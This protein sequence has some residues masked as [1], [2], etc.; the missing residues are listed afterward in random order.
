MASNLDDLLKSI[1]DE[2]KK[3]SAIVTVNGGG[4]RE[5]RLVSEQ[6]DERILRLLG[7]E[8]VFD[9]DYATYKTL[10]RE[11]MA[12]A[13][14]TGANIPAEE[15]ELIVGEFKRV[16][17][18]SGRFKVK[19]KKIKAGDIRRTSS[20][21]R[22]RGVTEPPQKLLAPA[23]EEAEKGPLDKIVESLN[24]IV[25]ILK[26]RNSLLKKRSEVERRNR[27][28]EE[29]AATESRFEKGFT[30]VAKVAEKIIAP[31]KSVLQKIIDY[32]MGLIV[33]RFLVKFIDWFADPK[34]QG[35]INAFGKFLSDH[36]PK[37][38]AAYLLFGNGFGRFV[39]KI[40][41]TLIRG[42]VSLLTK[43]LPRLLSFIAANPVLAAIV[44]GGA[45]FAAGGVL[46][47]MFPGLT[48]DDAD[49]QADKAS[50]SKG[51]NQ[52]ATDIENQNKNRNFLQ[53]FGDFITGA[54]AER[55]EQAYRL[56]TGEDKK[57][58]F[59]G[60]GLTPRGTDVVPAMLSPGEFIMSKGAVDAYGANTLAALNAAAG[61][62]NRPSTIGGTTYAAGGGYVEGKEKV[63]SSARRPRD[64][65]SIFPTVNLNRQS[66]QYLVRALAEAAKILS[67]SNLG[68]GS[69]REQSLNQPSRG[70]LGERMMRG[71]QQASSYLSRVQREIQKQV[72]GSI[73]NLS[74]SVEGL[75][76]MDYGS[77]MET[78]KG[79]VGAAQEAIPALLGGIF[80]MDRVDRN[81]SKE[82]QKALLDAQKVAKAKGRDFVEYEDYAKG[83]SGMAAKLTM[84]R[85]GNSE[86]KRD[87]KG[88]ITGL[89]QVYDTNRSAEEAM[90]QAGDS[91]KDFLKTGN[92]KSLMRAIYK[93]GEAL[94][95]SVQ[96]RG[97][98]T[99]DVDFSEDVL[100]FKPEAAKPYYGPGGDPSGS[101]R[102][103][104]QIAK[105]R[106]SIKTPEPPAKPQVSVVVSESQRRRTARRGGRS[107]NNLPGINASYSSKDKSRNSKILG[108]F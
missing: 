6:I 80:G 43:V 76:K 106:P 21:S 27:E 53:Q 33:G 44:G 85:I 9:I 58:G 101:G 8:D 19:K 41:A 84:G 18:S 102:G 96:S 34:N 56:R 11:R 86:W 32:F 81:I 87:A 103:Q 2:A 55:E 50:K 104:A 10:L 97:M 36:W 70:G 54:G 95:A 30:K 48:K 73:S 4:N 3:E 35:K 25:Q 100:G 72:G 99:H 24:N 15:D 22:L 7:L 39:V 52:A 13:R 89:R 1:R 17:R 77:V 62:T 49:K 98:T 78:V 93:P 83:A 31:V 66:D 88:R 107:S 37:L 64:F 59:S 40:T 57:Y 90:Q 28:K 69:T 51:N 79:A 91:I 74:K 26:D 12:S 63:P 75:G 92:P 108:I 47:A 65:A 42:T 46:P 29:R 14:M 82:M 71:G 61:G 45:L 67:N 20:V 68:G 38:L 105:V 16:K 23:K 5:E 60:G 94:L